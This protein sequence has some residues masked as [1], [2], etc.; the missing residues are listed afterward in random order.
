MRR[1]REGVSCGVLQRKG[2]GSHRMLTKWRLP[3]IDLEAVPT[4]RTVGDLWKVPFKAHSGLR[5]K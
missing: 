5:S 3:M 1:P 2:H 4:A